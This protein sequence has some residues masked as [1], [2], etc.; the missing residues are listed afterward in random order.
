[1]E[2]KAEGEQHNLDEQEAALAAQSASLA[3][4]KKRRKE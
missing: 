4:T 2:P 3:E 1:M